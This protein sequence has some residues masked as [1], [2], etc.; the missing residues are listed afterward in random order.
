MAHE[1]TYLCFIGTFKTT[2]LSVLVTNKIVTKSNKIV[3]DY[4]SIFKAFYGS[5]YV[6]TK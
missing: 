4:H 3:I 2:P 1:G 6:L 5:M